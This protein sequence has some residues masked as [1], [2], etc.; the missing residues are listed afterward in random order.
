M[1]L[2]E[3]ISVHDRSWPSEG[4]ETSQTSPALAVIHFPREYGSPDT[5]D[6]TSG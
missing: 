3:S 4:M 2:T 1:N 5:P 6:I